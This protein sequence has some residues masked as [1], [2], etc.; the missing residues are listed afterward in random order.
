MGGGTGTGASTGTGQQQLPSWLTGAFGGQATS[1]P[2]P[3]PPA[4]GSTST[5]SGFIPAGQQAPGQQGNLGFSAAGSPNWNPMSMMMWQLMNGGMQQPSGSGGLYGGVSGGMPDWMKMFMGG[6]TNAAAT[7]AAGAPPPGDYMTGARNSIGHQ[8]SL[9]DPSV[10]LPKVQAPAP[11]APQAAAP[12]QQPQ[13]GWAP[14]SGPEPAVNMTPEQK[15][16]LLGQNYAGWSSSP[17][18]VDINSPEVREWQRWALGGDAYTRNVAMAAS[19]EGF[20]RQ[21]QWNKY[22]GPGANTGTYAGVAPAGYGAGQ[23]FTGWGYN[24]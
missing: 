2:P 1:P 21:D 19:N 7:P 12:Q 15:Q 6:T 11:A 4:T 20:A 13:L 14:R 16:A 9:F 23:V 22:G 10:M 3:P 17:W 8:D 18:K 5:P 24:N